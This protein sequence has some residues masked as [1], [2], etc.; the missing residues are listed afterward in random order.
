[1]TQELPG[2]GRKNG[3]IGVIEPE[4]AGIRN[5]LTG[6]RLRIRQFRW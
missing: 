1:M 4:I 2:L 5:Q 3:S 6:V